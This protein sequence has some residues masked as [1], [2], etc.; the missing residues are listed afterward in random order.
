MLNEQKALMPE[1]SEKLHVTE[2]TETVSVSWKPE[3]PEMDEFESDMNDSKRAEEHISE[4][5]QNKED[6]FKK[7]DVRLI[8]D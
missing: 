7:I 3:R 1:D 2:E 5:Q 6:S 8:K 4:E